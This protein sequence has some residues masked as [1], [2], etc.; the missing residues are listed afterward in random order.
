MSDLATVLIGAGT[1]LVG[2]GAIGHTEVLRRQQLSAD[3]ISR[4]TSLHELHY[5]PDFFAHVAL[6]VFTIARKWSLLTAEARA[7][8]RDSVLLG[9]VGY[10]TIESLEAMVGGSLDG[11]A[12]SHYVPA[13]GERGL[14][15]HEALTV[16]L[17]FWTRVA[18][19]GRLR[20]L[21]RD[22]ARE[23]FA[24][25]Y[26]YASPFFNDLVT[27]ITE[28]LGVDE[29]LPQWVAAVAYLDEWFL[30]EVVPMTA[31]DD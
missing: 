18:T 16:S 10:N 24:W 25:P 19:L 4:A 15:E 9:W 8:Y 6:P 13:M 31:A 1:I 23:L 27:E 14:N 2:V 11:A 30:S 21:D 17:Y 5:S 26:S 22:V 12:R 3:R 7:E 29:V 28:R 20:L